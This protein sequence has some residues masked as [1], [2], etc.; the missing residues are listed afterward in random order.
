MS[1]K[2]ENEIER[3]SK[4]KSNSD[5]TPKKEY[6][7]KVGNYILSD[8]IGIGTFS[9]VTKAIHTLTGEKV[10]VKILD[11]SKIK[12]NIDIE[13]I[14]REIEILKSISHPNISQLYESNSTIHNFYLI[15]EYIEGGDLCDYINKNV[16]LNEHLA[17]R[18]FRQL[19]SV[20]EYLNEMGITHRDIKPENIL[21]DSTQKNIKVI[22]FGLSN[23]CAEKELLQSACGSP[24]FASPEMLSGNPYNGITTDI[25]SSGIV[26]YSMLVGTLPFDDQE[27]NAL[28][29]QI[30]IGTFYIPSTLSLESIDFLKKILRVNPDKRLNLNQ[31]KE[32][33]WFNI[34]KN[35]L[36]KGIDLTVETFPYNE[37]LILY[38][39]NKFFDDDNDIN[40]NNFIKM[41]QY[42][43]CNQYTATYYLTL[44]F[45][46]NNKDLKDNLNINLNNNENIDYDIENENEDDINKKECLTSKN[47]LN[48]KN[49]E[50]MIEKNIQNFKNEE[51][52]NEKKKENLK[53]EIYKDNNIDIDVEKNSDRTHKNTKS[54][55]VKNQKEK[56]NNNNSTSNSTI[57]KNKNITNNININN[58][59]E[60]P[61]LS[62]IKK[63]L[64]LY[65]KSP[66][67]YSKTKKN[68]YLN[69]KK[70]SLFPDYINIDNN[71]KLSHRINT[72]LEC[73]R[74]FKNSENISK[75]KT[76]KT[77]SWQK[78]EKQKKTQKNKI[79]NK[80]KILY[81][82][83]K[84][85]RN[86]LT[87]YNFITEYPKKFDN[88]NNNINQ[89]SNQINNIRF[90]GS[91]M[92]KENISV[93]DRGNFSSSIFTEEPKILSFNNSKMQS[94]KN[95]KSK[96]NKINLSYKK[97]NVSNNS[98][99]AKNYENNSMNI[100]KNNFLNKKEKKNICV[101][102]NLN[103][104]KKFPKITFKKFNK[105]KY[106]QTNIN[107]EYKKIKVYNNKNYI[108]TDHN[109]ERKDSKINKIKYPDS[110]DSSLHMKK[111][112]YENNNIKSHN[113]TINKYRELIDEFNSEHSENKNK[114][115]KFKKIVT[116]LEN[117][118]FSSAI[119]KYDEKTKIKNR[120]KNILLINPSQNHS[121]SKNKT[122]NN[123]SHNNINTLSQNY[124]NNIDDNLIKRKI[125]KNSIKN[126]KHIAINNGKNNQFPSYKYK[127]NHLKI[128][129]GYI[130][131]KI[132][133]NNFLGLLSTKIKNK[134]NM[135]KTHIKNSS[136]KK[137]YLSFMKTTKNSGIKNKK[138][139]FSQ[140]I[141]MSPE[142]SNNNIKNIDNNNK[143]IINININNILKINKKYSISLTKSSDSSKHSIHYN[144]PDI[145]EKKNL[146]GIK[147]YNSSYPL[148]SEKNKKYKGAIKYFS[149]N[150]C[151]NRNDIIYLKMNNEQKTNK[152]YSSMLKK[153][154]FE[155]QLF[156]ENKNF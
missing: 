107:S 83:N 123:I 85:T 39:M 127:K 100:S 84:I 116:K 1:E 65:K 27:L 96:N 153:Q 124:S 68:S 86:H 111:I 29:E 24:C 30:K 31:I 133:N 38:V 10:A 51:I 6:S 90:A 149:N 120:N 101:N 97:S 122:L 112:G 78:K 21:L 32:H 98:K 5:F 73:I 115:N 132:N 52:I 18:F 152:N 20:I 35:K 129:I 61:K 79:K 82:K 148:I 12:D 14:S 44:N 128:D 17:C 110:T 8:Q 114:K 130:N 102:I 109:H 103:I 113:N 142:S 141:S 155:E 145:S 147:N 89:S 121:I 28:Y 3:K 62:I 135:N 33:P 2:T 150:T 75:N 9:K 22:D 50:I 70:L 77:K 81:D 106:I 34:E 87:T 143:K 71:K 139:P 99:K 134:K 137:N 119:Q 146:I 76:T 56:N 53:D 156:N 41:I 91:F 118:Y 26:L 105:K 15:M 58:N 55:N 46:K 54:N 66:Y 94:I 47:S 95:E 151:R 25:W 7:K 154:L 16:C 88:N 144:N 64:I 40:K 43:A 13:R 93:T 69:P 138:N 19:I 48:R 42:H 57:N 72:I 136:Y 104:N 80:N 117:E 125:L 59:K 63:D 11:K 74:N 92:K 140:N 126:K 4:L 131:S 45:I 67:N 36:Y 108:L 60:N 49:L 23:Y 37:Q